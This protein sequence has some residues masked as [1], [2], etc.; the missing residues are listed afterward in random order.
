[1]PK[2][3]L[4]QRFLKKEVSLCI[5]GSKPYSTDDEGVLLGFDEQGILLGNDSTD[6]EEL[7]LLWIPRK[8]ITAIWTRE[9][10]RGRKCR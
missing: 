8:E 2:K 9:E 1:M 3:D 5:T 10:K 6:G 4:L 7:C